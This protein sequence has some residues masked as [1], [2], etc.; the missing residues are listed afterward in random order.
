MALE[1]IDH[2]GIVVDDMAAA[3]AFFGELGMDLLGETP[4]EGDWVDRIVGLEGL[5]VDSATMQTPDEKGRIELIKFNAPPADVGDSRA[6]R[7]HPR[8]PPPGLRRRR[9]RRH[10][11]PPAPPRRRARRHGGELPRRVPP[12]LPP[13][14]GGHDRRAGP[15][16]RLSA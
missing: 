10:R 6:P 12:L 4:V 8:P 11:R 13:R 9:R 2:V 14:P 5:Q 16:A 3:I 7:Q 15:A 1:R